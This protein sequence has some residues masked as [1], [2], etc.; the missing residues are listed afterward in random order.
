LCLPL[1]VALLLAAIAGTLLM[2]AAG[3]AR[4]TLAAADHAPRPAQ[5]QAGGRCAMGTGT[6][7]FLI[8]AGAA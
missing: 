4:I 1:A 3:T 6:G 7:I 2:A 8:T 5:A